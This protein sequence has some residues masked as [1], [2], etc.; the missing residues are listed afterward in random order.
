M[1]AVLYDANVRCF[2]IGIERSDKV[3]AFLVF[4]GST[5]TTLS[6]VTPSSRQAQHMQT[7]KSKR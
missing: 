6:S 2:G 1:V 7:Q 5:S 3:A 4:M